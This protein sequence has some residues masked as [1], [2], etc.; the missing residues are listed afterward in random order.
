MEEGHGCG[1]RGVAK[2]I[3]GRGYERVYERV[4]SGMWDVWMYGKMGFRYCL[5]LFFGG[6]LFMRGER[7]AI[8]MIFGDVI[9]YS[10][11]LMQL[12]RR[13]CGYVRG[14]GSLGSCVERLALLEGTLS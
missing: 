3:L 12:S 1:G 2:S 13:A 11:S 9:I 10:L 8:H 7:G 5:C 14:A 4:V 6:C